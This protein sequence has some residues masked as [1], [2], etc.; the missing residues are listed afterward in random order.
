MTWLPRMRR[1]FALWLCP[2]FDVARGKRHLER[3]ARE[4]GASKSVAT[5]IAGEFFR[6]L[7][8]AL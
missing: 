6:S 1:R 5:K 8:D 4:C 7:R 3:I 2:E